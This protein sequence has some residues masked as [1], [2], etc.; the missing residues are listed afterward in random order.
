MKVNIEW[1][2]RNDQNLPR[3]PKI[4]IFAGRSWLIF[5]DF[6][7][8]I[9][10]LHQ[11]SGCFALLALVMVAFAR[12]NLPLATIIVL[13]FSGPAHVGARAK[14]YKIHLD[15]QERDLIQ[16]YDPLRNL[17]VACTFLVECYWLTTSIHGHASCS[18]IISYRILC[19]LWYEKL[20]ATNAVLPYQL[21][22]NETICYATTSGFYL[23]C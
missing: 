4:S 17:R 5:F 22:L 21:G 1:R 6:N 7:L 8:P 23:R 11:Y 12:G 16:H 2:I 19:R 14:E 13:E 20:G 10:Y 18:W 3:I 15:L 9:F